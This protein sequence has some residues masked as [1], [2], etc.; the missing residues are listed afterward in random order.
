MIQ[1]YKKK[2]YDDWYNSLTEEQKQRLE[3]YQKEEAKKR[4]RDGEMELAMIAKI[5][6][7]MNQMT[8]GRMSDYIECAKIVNR[9]RLH[10]SEYW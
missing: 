7:S 5:F 10:P 4:K 9:I 8:H 2:I 3:E 1:F 6:N